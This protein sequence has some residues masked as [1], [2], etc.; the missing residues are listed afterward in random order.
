MFGDFSEKVSGHEEGIGCHMIDMDDGEHVITGC[1]DGY[2]RL[3]QFAPN[4]VRDLISYHEI[5][6]DKIPIL[7]MAK[8]HCGEIIGTISTDYS[9]QFH[10]I[11]NIVEK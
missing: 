4:R 10:D 1:D 9:I 11:K 8:S 6:N 7:G 2:L 5:D 3:V